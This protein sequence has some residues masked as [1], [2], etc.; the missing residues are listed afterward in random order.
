MYYSENLRLRAPERSDIPAFTEWIND[1]EVIDGLTI[2]YPMS[3]EDESRWFDHMVQQPLELHP[4][5]IEVKEGDH[6]QAIGNC[7]FHDVDWRN[8][9]AEFGIFIGDK[10]YWG[11]G[12]GSEAIQLLLKVGFEVMNLH[13]IW[14]RVKAD[15][16]RAVHSYEKIGFVH[17]GRKREAEYHHGEYIDM[18]LMSILRYEWKGLPDGKD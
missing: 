5:V 7:G 15:N 1:P 12:Y 11:K 18:L 10:N 13:R 8:S 6:W 17:E 4:W 3:S 9:N 2:V 14:L 16:P